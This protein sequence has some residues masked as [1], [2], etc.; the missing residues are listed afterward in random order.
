MSQSFYRQPRF[1]VNPVVELTESP[2]QQLTEDYD[3][4]C[5]FCTKGEQPL[6]AYDFGSTLGN[7]NVVLKPALG[8]L[9]PGYF[10]TVTRKHLTSF[11]QLPAEALAEIDD[12]LTKSEEYLAPKFGEYFRVEHGSDNVTTCGSGGC[13]D[14]AHQHLVPA[15]DVADHAQELLPWQQLDDFT[16]ITQFAG[17]PY[18]YMGRQGEHYV[19]PNPDLPSQ[20]IRRQIAEVRGLEHWDW[21]VYEG[22]TELFETLLKLGSFPVGRMVFNLDRDIAQ[23]MPHPD[24]RL[25]GIH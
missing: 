10:L 14:H 18:I 24:W 16:D 8:M 17:E 5:E 22:A 3:P 12:T 25:K 6:L 23:Y 21:A 9:I 15:M 20:W 7:G 19:V 2:T 4:T 13:I 1:D 11:A